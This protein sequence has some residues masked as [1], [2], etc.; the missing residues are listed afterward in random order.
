LI[1]V[2]GGGGAGVTTLAAATAVLIARGGPPVRLYGVDPAA[3]HAA[4]G[5]DT[6]RSDGLEICA[7]GPAAVFGAEAGD[8]LGWLRALLAWAGIDRGLERDV[9]RL[10]VSR[11]AGALLAASGHAPGSAVVD[12][13]PAAEALPLLQLLMTDPASDAGTEGLSRLATRLAGP[14]VTRFVDLP[15]P[16][17]AVRSAGR[18]VGGRVHRLRELLRDSAVT[19]LR[20]LLPADAR[21]ARIEQEVRTVAGLHGIGLDALVHRGPGPV[22]RDYDLP[23]LLM[24]WCEA[25]SSAEAG[26]IDLARSVYAGCD[27]MAVP[28]TPRAPRIE[29]TETGAVLMLPLPERPATEFRVTRRG[30]RLTIH[31]GDW[32]RTMI[33]PSPVDT[34]VGRRAWHDGRDFRVQFER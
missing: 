11:L 29:L 27:P 17:A 3:L 32:Q 12:M 33:L 26:L 14:V 18:H 6:V 24:P 28:A 15:Q 10:H 20:V 4:V 16:D 13:G 22:I 31:A 2:T 21:A 25:P 7:P 5:P 9:A 23:R 34:L 30:A 19:S 8:L 1:L